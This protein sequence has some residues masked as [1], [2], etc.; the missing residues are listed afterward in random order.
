MKRCRDMEDGEISLLARLGGLHS[1]A[2]VS[3][4]AGMMMGRFQRDRQKAQLLQK[5]GAGGE[6]GD[7]LKDL[8]VWI[9]Q[10]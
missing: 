5:A 1:G 9:L 2:C 3:V 6:G 7:H 4:A 8:P 10:R